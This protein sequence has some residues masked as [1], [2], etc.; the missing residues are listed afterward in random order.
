MPEKEEHIELR[1][2]EVEEIIS[3][4]P[5]WMIRWGNTLI[6]LLVVAGIFMT[7]LI[8]YPD[9]ITG[10]ATITT[11]KESIQ[12]VSQSSGSISYLL[13]EGTSVKKGELIAS[14][15]SNLTSNSQQILK[16]LISDLK[17]SIRGSDTFHFPT[18]NIRFGELHERY[19]ELKK[20]YV[21][22]QFFLRD[23]SKDFEIQNIREQI[24][25]HQA[26]HSVTQMQVSVAKEL[27]KNA[28]DKHASAKRLFD[29]GAISKKTWFDEQESFAQSKNRLAETKNAQVQSTIVLTNLKKDLHELETEKK[30]K[31]NQL[32]NELHLIISNIENQ[33]ENW[34]SK[35]EIFAPYTGELAYLENLTIGEYVNVEQNL[36]AV[37]PTNRD[38]IGRLKVPKEG[39]GKLEVGQTVRVSLDS[40]PSTE[41]G[42]IEGRVT[43]VAMLPNENFYRIEF[44]LNKGMISTYGKHLNYKPNLSGKA[45][46]ITQE[47]RLIQRI[48]NNFKNL[49]D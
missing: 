8:K 5:N 43:S 32:V 40:Y 9:V 22:Y 1:S 28:T 6:L 47:L 36:L 10:E 37:I 45:E 29:E 7:W 24:R 42:L 15:Q 41:Y 23:D 14:I 25:N 39:V 12:L 18:S 34:S 46:V 26:L 33:L 49:F 44:E 4:V 16:S 38:F 20:V 3:L 31:E 19:S 2:D 21:D 11:K 17:K 30:R 48:F 27:L 35:Y 13:P